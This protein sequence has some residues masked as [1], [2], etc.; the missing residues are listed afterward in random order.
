M[1]P[2]RW[3]VSGRTERE[4]KRGLPLTNGAEA[5]T[6][7][8]R[9]ERSKQGSLHNKYSRA[10]RTHGRSWRVAALAGARYKKRKSEEGNN[11]V[12]CG[13]VAASVGQRVGVSK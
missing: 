1:W 10:Q 3:K 5:D 13:T 9:S 6:Q 4:R 11:H 12:V 8:V 2:S 7:W